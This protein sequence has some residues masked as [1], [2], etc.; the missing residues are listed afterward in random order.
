MKS[1][2][3]VTVTVTVT[4]TVLFI[5]ATN[6]VHD[7]RV[8]SAGTSTHKM[9]HVCVIISRLISQYSHCDMSH[10]NFNIVSCGYRH[11]YIESNHIATHI[12]VFTLRYES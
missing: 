4:S 7:A 9:A 11:T 6:R 10:E 2:V 1:R 5:K 3:T 8:H 12:A